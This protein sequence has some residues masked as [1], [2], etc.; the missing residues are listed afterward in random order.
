MFYYGIEENNIKTLLCQKLRQIICRLQTQLRIL[1]PMGLNI[2]LPNGQFMRVQINTNIGLKQRRQSADFCPLPAPN[3][4]R[5]HFAEVQTGLTHSRCNK[6]LRLV[7]SVLECRAIMEVGHGTLLALEIV[8]FAIGG[9]TFLIPCP[10]C[11]G[12]P[13]ASSPML[14]G[15]LMRPLPS[16]LSCDRN[17]KLLPDQHDIS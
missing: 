11:H 17:S 7:E 9:S 3:F 14:A 6:A 1:D 8:Y 16:E 4:Q 15:S 5:S 10:N 2:G 13:S 12:T